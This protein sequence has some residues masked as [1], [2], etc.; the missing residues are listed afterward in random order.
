VASRAATSSRDE[1]SQKNQAS[2]DA[3]DV[4]L[5]AGN[6]EAEDDVAEGLISVRVTRYEPREHVASILRGEPVDV[7]A[8]PSSQV[9]RSVCRR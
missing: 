2:A 7:R 9:A 3:E 5:A 8:M 1:T 6:E 4:C